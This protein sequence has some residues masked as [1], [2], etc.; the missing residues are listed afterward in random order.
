MALFT[1]HGRTQ[2]GN[3]GNASVAS[4]S[5]IETSVPSIV[6]EKGCKTARFWTNFFTLGENRAVLHPFETSRAFFK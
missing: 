2:P 5:I 3:R 1:P 4:L 6:E